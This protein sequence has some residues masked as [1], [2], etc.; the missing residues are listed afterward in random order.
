[1]REAILK[2]LF[3]AVPKEEQEVWARL[4]KE[5]HDNAVKKWK[6]EVSSG[7]STEPEDR[8]RYVST[9]F[10]QWFSLILPQLYSRA[11]G[12]LYSYFGSHCPSYW[13]ESYSDR[14]RAGAGSCW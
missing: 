7:P 10:S 12:V 14:W 2:E 13:L 8:Q 6:E 5:E 3:A 11:Y 1:M 4:A 9:A